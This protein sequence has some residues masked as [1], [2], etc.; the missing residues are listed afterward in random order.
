MLDMSRTEKFKFAAK[1]IF[2]E[3][4]MEEKDW[5]SIYAQIL[6]KAGKQNLL[7]AKDFIDEKVAEG[8]LPPTVAAELKLLLDRFKKRR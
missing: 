4:G 3:A 5:G 2:S 1:R 8:R 7:A 6:T